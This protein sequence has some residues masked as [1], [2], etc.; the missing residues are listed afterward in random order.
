M[1]AVH[2]HEGGKLVIRKGTVLP[3]DPI[4]LFLN[5]LGHKAN[6]GITKPKAQG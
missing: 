5:Q 2:H 6:G 3:V 4:V 1:Y